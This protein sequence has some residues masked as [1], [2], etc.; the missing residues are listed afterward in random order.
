MWIWFQKRI[1][2]FQFLIFRPISLCNVCYKLI[3][4]IIANKLNQVLIGKEQVGFLH[5]KLVTD[6]IIA[7]QEATHSLKK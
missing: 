2:P 4:K 5:G 7:I 6:N 1:I 3:A